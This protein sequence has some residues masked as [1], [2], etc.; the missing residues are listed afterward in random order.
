VAKDLEINVDLSS[1][2]PINL[3]QKTHNSIMAVIFYCRKFTSRYEHPIPL[4]EDPIDVFGNIPQE[5]RKRPSVPLSEQD[6]EIS[7]RGEKQFRKCLAMFN[8]F[9]E[10]GEKIVITDSFKSLKDRL[11]KLKKDNIGNFNGPGLE[12]ISAQFEKLKAHLENCLIGRKME[13]ILFEFLESQEFR[14]DVAQFQDDLQIEDGEK[15]YEDV[16]RIFDI[17]ASNIKIEPK[18]PSLYSAMKNFYNAVKNFYDTKPK[19]VILRNWFDLWS[20]HSQCMFQYYKIFGFLVHILR[21]YA[22]DFALKG[23]STNY[24]MKFLDF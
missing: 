16:K 13:P 14:E 22:L 9:V 17:V 12:K 2:L 3:K 4:H 24:I 11:S 5:W 6:L 7:Q 21:F 19:D 23:R 8:L 18:L 1:D 15:F 10:N 20:V